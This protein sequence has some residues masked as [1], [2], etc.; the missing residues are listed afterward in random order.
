MTIKKQSNNIVVIET[1]KTSLKV[2]KNGK[3]LT[4]N[5]DSDAYIINKPG[6]YE[7]SDIFFSAQNVPENGI[8]QPEINFLNINSEV[9]NVGVYLNSDLADK[10]AL[11]DIAEV[12]IM[13]VNDEVS[14]ETFRKLNTFFEA[15]VVVFL[16]SL[17]MDDIKKKY[18][19]SNILEEKSLKFKAGELAARSEDAPQI[20]YKI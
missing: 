1:N 4:V 9:T 17:S 2:L 6:E 14:E 11:K 19:I 13:I 20:F 16:S 10:E 18:S 7:V 3:S 5:L 12:Q 15:D 8:P